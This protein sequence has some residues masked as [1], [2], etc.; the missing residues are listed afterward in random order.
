MSASTDKHLSV[1]FVSSDEEIVKIEGNIATVVGSG[2]VTIT[3]I[4]DGNENYE[5][6]SEE[7][8]MTIS[9]EEEIPE[10]SYSIDAEKGTMTLRFTCKLYESED[11]IA[12]ILVEGAKDTYTVSLKQG[13][14]KLYCAGK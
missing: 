9:G 7:Q 3:A 14:M 6:V 4:Q 12:W 8:T 5:A 1:R 2:T 11:G 13:K 10:I